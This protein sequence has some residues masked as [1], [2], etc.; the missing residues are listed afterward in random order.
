[1]FHEPDRYFDQYVNQLTTENRTLEQSMLLYEQMKISPSK[2]VLN[3]L[4]QLLHQHFSD[5]ES[6][7]LLERLSRQRP[8]TPLHELLLRKYLDLKQID[9]ASLLLLQSNFELT[10]ADMK[11]LHTSLNEMSPEELKIQPEALQNLLLKLF[12]QEPNSSDVLLNK[13]L[14]CLL[15]QYEL[16][17][18]HDWLEPLREVCGQLDVI[19]KFDRIYKMSEDLENMQ[20]LG[21]LYFEF[22]QWN[23]ALDC[24]S[25]ESELKPDEARPLKWL[26]KTYLEMGLKDESEAYQKMYVNLQKQA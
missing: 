21:E 16:T 23:Q 25:M 22:K 10:T 12:K 18:V 7:D 8:F 20:P 24:F 2:Q 9:R 26:S 1:M 14:I 13:C 3:S 5:Q 15:A 6:V 4:N 19:Q 11:Q 17:D